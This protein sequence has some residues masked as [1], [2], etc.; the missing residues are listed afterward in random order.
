MIGWYSQRSFLKAMFIF[1]MWMG[2]GVIYG[3]VF[4]GWSFITALYYAVTSCSTAGLLGVPCIDSKTL[5]TEH[6][7]LGLNRAA[8][9][10][11]YSMLGVPSK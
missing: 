2:I 3:M 11:T 5:A 6:C 7:D 8:L 1:I 9:A 4:E 10:A